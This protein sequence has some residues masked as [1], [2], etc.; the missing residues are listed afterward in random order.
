MHISCSHLASGLSQAFSSLIAKITPNQCSI[1]F[2]KITSSR[3]PPRLET[4]ARSQLLGSLYA[5]RDRPDIV[6][7]NT[8]IYTAVTRGRIVVIPCPGMRLH[9]NSSKTLIYTLCGD[10]A[11]GSRYYIK[12]RGNPA[13]AALES[14][15][16][17]H[18]VY[19]TDK[20]ENSESVYSCESMRTYLYI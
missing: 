9:T 14:D 1:D 16:I 19:S 5:F 20:G 3:T 2:R 13:A 15:A 6:T 12:S 7:Y 18:D 10:W 17:T 8:H 11:S 4:T